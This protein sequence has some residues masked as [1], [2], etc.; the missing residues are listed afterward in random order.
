MNYS[1]T[2]IAYLTLLFTLGYLIYRFFQYWKKEK[3]VTA[4]QSLY[5]TGLFGLFVLINTISGLFF[6]NNFSVLEKQEESA[7][8]FRRLP[9]PLWLTILFILNFPEFLPGWV[10]F[11]FLF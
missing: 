6:A 7:L 4:K 1:I 11:Q 2:G 8:L 10:L 5:F 9:L 3:D